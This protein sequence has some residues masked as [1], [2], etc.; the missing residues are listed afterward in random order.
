MACLWMTDTEEEWF[1]NFSDNFK[2]NIAREINNS[3]Y[4]SFVKLR[5]E[6]KISPEAIKIAEDFLPKKNGRLF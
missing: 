4:E 3:Y 5:L 1:L 2:G 6:N